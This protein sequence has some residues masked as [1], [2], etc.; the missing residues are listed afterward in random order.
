MSQDDPQAT[1]ERIRAVKQAHEKALLDKANVV[2]VG[3]GLRQRGGTR[4]D[5]MVLVVMVK[6]K[7]P[8]HQLAPADV[9]PGD[10]EGV[11][12]D[13]QVVGDIRATP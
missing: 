1:Y 3:I 11:P 5:Q 12:V 6:Q 4:T 2:G 13:V 7:V 10:I 8:R 9:I